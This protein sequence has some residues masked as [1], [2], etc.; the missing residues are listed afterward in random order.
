MNLSE[1]QKESCE[2]FKPNNG[3]TDDQ[4]RMVNWALGITGESGELAN[5]IKHVVFHNEDVPIQ[6]AAKE[7][8][9]ILWY[10][11]A[12][13]TTLNID[14]G[15]CAELN[16]AKLKHR[17]GRSFSFDRSKDRHHREKMFELT[18]EYE[19]LMR[20]LFNE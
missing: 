4:I 13:C 9:D 3:I 19:Q 18:E 16:L 5:M 2:T 1:Y 12:L 6:E 11:A 14:L 15:V 8:G 7:I 20:R 17:H 10:L